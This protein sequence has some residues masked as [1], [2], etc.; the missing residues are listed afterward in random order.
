[1]KLS[2]LFTRTEKSVSQ[3]DISINAQ[4]LE[5][6]GFVYKNSSGVYTY[7]PLGWRVISK[8]NQI[9]REEMNAIGGQEMLMPALVSKRYW[10]ASDRW[11]VDIAYKLKDAGD[12]EFALGWTHEEVLAEI[13][14]RYIKSYKDLPFSAYQ[15][16]TKFRNEPRAKSG[17]LRGREFIMKDLYSFHRDAEDLNKFYWQVAEA[18][19]K[20]F[21]RCGL[22]AYIAEASGGDFTKEYTHEF[23]VLSE[24][25]EDSIFY[26]AECR[27]AQNKEISTLANGGKCPKCG[28]KV[29][30][31]KA[32]EVGN[33]FRLGTRFSEAFDLNYVD[34]HGSSH[35]VVMGSYGI[36]PS[37]V[38]GT[39]AEVFHDDNGLLWPKAVAPFAVYLI[40][41]DNKRAEADK[42][43]EQL[44][45]AGVEVLY[46]NN[47]ERSAGE[48]FADADLLGIPT[49]L[50]ISSKTLKENS[51]ERKT[52]GSSA[53]E[54]VK[55]T[56]IVKELRK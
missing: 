5:R 46:D 22:E 17:V 21:Q 36:G 29:I 39:L 24:A 33:I 23:Q 37:R 34:E 18:Y 6:G 44:R 56:E 20:I 40:M 55:L 16:Q 26:C 10:E 38:L 45:A 31:G 35:L 7:L 11:N 3:E 25:G 12:H 43:F 32:I 28:G 13:S 48:K 8:I 14:R 27:Y 2:E 47:D 15:I 49:R 41:L 51:V 19:T 42:L 4:L 54:L 52:R 53:T 30:L 1:M 9:I 50:L